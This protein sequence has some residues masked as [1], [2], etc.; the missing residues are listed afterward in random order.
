[1][2]ETIRKKKIEIYEYTTT[3]GAVF[4]GDD[5]E[6]KAINHQR[7]LDLT[8]QK[9]NLKKSL[10]VIFGFDKNLYEEDYYPNDPDDG[11]SDVIELDK[12]MNE[13]FST[14]GDAM[15]GEKP[16]SF[17]EFVDAIF[18]IFLEHFDSC[19]KIMRVFYH[20]INKGQR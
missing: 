20:Y 4:I 7:I 1:M 12:K 15:C 14:F 5:A 16:D 3:D 18:E 11:E 17:G 19:E 8:S 2:N 13:L 9:D 6:K 10:W